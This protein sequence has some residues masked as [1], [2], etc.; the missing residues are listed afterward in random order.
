MLH[1]LCAD[2]FQRGKCLPWPPCLLCAHGGVSV[3]PKF[4]FFSSIAMMN[5]QPKQV[6]WTRGTHGCRGFP[7]PLARQGTA[8]NICIFPFPMTAGWFAAWFGFSFPTPSQKLAGQ[9]FGETETRRKGPFPRCAC[10]SQLQNATLT[11]RLEA[12]AILLLHKP[13]CHYTF[14]SP[15]TSPVCPQSH[16]SLPPPGPMG[17]VGLP[18][19]SGTG[20]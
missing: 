16:V 2:L 6:L 3:R 20:W 4:P 15:K 8:G 10:F 19:S 11:P 7:G 1:N 5:F 9:G 14:A 17:A 13:E 12:H 18:W